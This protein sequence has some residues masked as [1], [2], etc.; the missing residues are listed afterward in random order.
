MIAEPL[1]AGAVHET[2][3][4]PSVWVLAWTDV[5]A[6]GMVD[7]VTGV[8]ALLGGLS[9]FP[10]V[11]VTVKVYPSPGFRPSIP[12]EVPEVNV[13]ERMVDVVTSKGVT[14]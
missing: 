14:V 8:E 6:S 9:P 1:S 12:I 13:A 10:F 3:T 11:A 2:F 7:A 4:L 5:G